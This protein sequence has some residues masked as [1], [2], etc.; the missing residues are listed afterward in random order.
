MP[1]YQAFWAEKRASLQADYKAVIKQYPDADAQYKRLFDVLCDIEDAAGLTPAAVGES[2]EWAAIISTAEGNR[3]NYCKALSGKTLVS[4]LYGNYTVTLNELKSLVKASAT[5]S[6]NPAQEEGFKEVRRRK[7]HS[8]TETAPTSKK[9]T[10]ATEIT[11]AKEVT[12]RNYFA[13]LRATM[14]TDTTTTEASTLEEEAPGK[15]GRPPR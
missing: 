10:A 1:G 3:V 12:T 13:P 4:A 8:T 15:A 7:R 6:K 11:A 2:A 5:G 14:D 9:T